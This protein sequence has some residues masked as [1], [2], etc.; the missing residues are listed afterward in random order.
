LLVQRPDITIKFSQFY[1]NGG[2]GF[3]VGFRV[4]F[5]V[6]GV[7]AQE[8]RGP[9]R[10]VEE[11]RPSPLLCRRFNVPDP[12]RG[13]V[14]PSSGDPRS[15]TDALSL[16]ETMAAAT[17]A[18]SLPLSHLAPGQPPFKQVSFYQPHPCLPTPSIYP[19]VIHPL[20]ALRSTWCFCNPPPPLRDQPCNSSSHRIDFLCCLVGSL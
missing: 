14:A 2:V 20:A 19:T 1:L 3:V 18:S 7:Q 13:K 5:K 8:P 16:P 17:A 6:S 15:R 9:R 11:W 10:T 12:F 4:G